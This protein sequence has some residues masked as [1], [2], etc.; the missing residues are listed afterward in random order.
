MIANQDPRNEVE[1]SEITLL[2]CDA[3]CQQYFGPLATLSK[4]SENWINMG[5]SL[6]FRIPCFE[7]V[8]YMIDVYTSMY[9]YV[10]Y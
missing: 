8:R 1:K 10:G 5:L 7:K 9:L 4:W 2:L 3:L 6:F